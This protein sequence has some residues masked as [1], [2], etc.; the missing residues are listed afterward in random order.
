[1]S[2][3]VSI[4]QHRES[5]ISETTEL[6]A[7]RATP[8]ASDPWVYRFAISTLGLLALL[9]LGGAL[10]LTGLGHEAPQVTVALGSAAVG[11][12]AGLLT[13]VSGRS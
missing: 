8:L 6:R 13:P 1:M 4:L 9:A 11:A 5:D 2:E 7:L 3:P 12:L 10:V